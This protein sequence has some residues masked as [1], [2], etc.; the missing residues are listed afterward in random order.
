MKVIFQHSEQQKNEVWEPFDWIT[1]EEIKEALNLPFRLIDTDDLHD[2]GE[3]RSKKTY[4]S[5]L[6]L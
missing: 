1:V 4:H 5:G 6:H 3:Y 2:A